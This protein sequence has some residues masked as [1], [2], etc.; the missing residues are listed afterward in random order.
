M[1]AGDS[2]FNERASKF[3]CITD[4]YNQKYVCYL[5]PSKC[6]LRCLKID[7]EVTGDSNQAVSTPSGILNY[8]PAR[9][10]VFVESR[11]LMVIIDTH[12]SLCV[13]SGLKKLCKLQL[14][15]IMWSSQQLASQAFCKQNKDLI[16]SP[17]I[18]PIKSKL[19]QAKGDLSNDEIQHQNL[20][21]TPKQS[22][23]AL[24]SK[25]VLNSSKL[26]LNSIRSANPANNLLQQQHEFKS[27]SDSTGSR[28]NVKL[29]DNRLVRVN[30]NESS[31]C[32][33]VNM[34]LEA[35]KYALN[36]EIYYEIIQQW[37]IHRY[38]IGGESV[39]DQLNL[40]LYLILNLCGCF[41]MGRLE[42]ELPFLITNSTKLANVK[43]VD[44][45]EP[46]LLADAAMAE[47]LDNLEA[48]QQQGA[49]STEPKTAKTKRAKCNYEGGD[50]DWDFLIGDESIQGL[51]EF[52]LNSLRSK[53]HSS[54]TKVKFE[55]V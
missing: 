31:T 46:E 54:G 33:M 22:N 15:N 39:R 17:I 42:H 49:E 24:F 27:V 2:T 38:T 51:N 43:R 23:E 12:G 11:N 13:Y 10:A 45:G 18:T 30:L 5:M 35:F 1:V 19:F 14:H 8:I 32:K 55:K 36:K 7:C 21:K 28:F 50:A 25:S 44:V 16:Q 3:F 47:N 48:S 41:D 4:L 40:F 37:Y 9:D 20:F 29:N 52:N 34:C 26:Q 6:Q 53:L